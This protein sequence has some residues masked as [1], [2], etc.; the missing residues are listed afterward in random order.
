MTKTTGIKHARGPRGGMTS[1]MEAFALLVA[2]G[3]SQ[4]MAYRKAY[5]HATL[6]PQDA[7]VRA[8]R[9]AGD[10]RIKARIEQL[11]GKSVTKALLTLNDRLNILSEIAQDKSAARSDRT[12]AIDVYNKMAPDGTPLRQEITGK[13]G[14]PIAVSATANVTVTG[15]SVREKAQRLRDAKAQRDADNVKPI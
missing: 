14:A 9:L 7:A 11:R 6:L 13:D 1:R 2:S 10:K 15:L 3:E 5:H 8:S 12:R 4:S